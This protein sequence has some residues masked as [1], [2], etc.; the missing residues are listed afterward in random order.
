MNRFVNTWRNA[1]FSLPQP[2]RIR[3]TSVSASSRWTGVGSR[4]SAP[5]AYAPTSTEVRHALGMAADVL[6]RDRSALRHAEQRK[7]RQAER[8]DDRLEVAHPDVERE[9]STIDPR[10]PSRADRSGCRCGRATARAARAATRGSRGR[11]RRGSASA[12]RAPAAA[13]SRSSR[14]RCACRRPRCRSARPGEGSWSDCCAA[15][16][17]PLDS[18]RPRCL[19]QRRPLALKPP[20]A[21]PGSARRASRRRRRRARVHSKPRPRR[22]IPASSASPRPSSDRRHREVHL[23]DEAGLQVLADGRDAA[24]DPHV[25]PAR[26]LACP[27]QR[28]VGCRR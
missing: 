18:A 4:F 14:R 19:V 15:A 28:G 27:V 12:T 25:L 17:G 11:A 7:A 23:V 26:G 2:T 21:P 6:D 9:P 1:A 5:R 3:L 22:S 16:R 8:V 24:A 10:V 20:A 13:R